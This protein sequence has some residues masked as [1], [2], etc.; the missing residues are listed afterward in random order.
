M[1]DAGLLRRVKASNAGARI[2]LVEDNEINQQV[3]LEL[4]RQAH[5]NVELAENG[6]IALTRLQVHDYDLVL[7]D[8]QMPVM[9][10]IAA[11]VELRGFPRHANLP[12]V[13]MTG[14]VLAADRQRCLD[15]GM[16]DFLAKPIEPVQLWQALLKWI[17]AHLAPAPLLVSSQNDTPSR[18]A[19]DLNIRGIDPIPALQRMLGNTE[20]YFATLRRFCTI[21]EYMP[22]ATRLALDADDWI[23]AQRCAHNLKN[24]AGSIG[25]NKLTEDAASLE[26]ALAE[27][28]PRGEAKKLIAALEV[29]LG[30]LIASARLSLP[31]MAAE[32]VTDLTGSTAAMAEF[33]AL[34]ADSDPEAMAWFD[35]NVSILRALLSASHL[36]KIQTAMNI[37]DFDDALNLLR[38]SPITDEVS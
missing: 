18:V 31:P 27:Y 24:A 36:A 4:L 19:I 26:Q 28:C 11:T 1:N 7:M 2:L 16:N 20:L 35:R 5:F 8:V 38:E 23:S 29:Q 17:P 9:D 32:V 12:I 30:N 6:Q 33:E 14:N 37:C 34:L 22:K 10:G 15:A 13:A 25:A 3:T 21:H